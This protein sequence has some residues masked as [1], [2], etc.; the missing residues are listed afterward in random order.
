MIS[1][2]DLM[3][4]LTPEMAVNAIISRDD[5]WHL[6]PEDVA[7]CYVDLQDGAVGFTTLKDGTIWEIAIDGA[8]RHRGA[9]SGCFWTEWEG[10]SEG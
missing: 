3:A 5:A 4:S 6:K 7:T 9:E 8:T 1:G 10:G 2:W